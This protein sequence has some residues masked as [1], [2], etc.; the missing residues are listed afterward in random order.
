MSTACGA[1]AGFL[2]LLAGLAF[3]L[4]GLGNLD[5]VTAHLLAG[6]T[7]GLYGLGLLVHVFGMC[8]MCK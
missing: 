7:L 2:V 8:P 3:L 6:V 4:L 5:S 1:V